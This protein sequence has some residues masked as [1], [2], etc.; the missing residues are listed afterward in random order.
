MHGNIFSGQIASNKSDFISLFEDIVVRISVLEQLILL[1]YE[2]FFC[3]CFMSFNGKI[4]SVNM[5]I[6]CKSFDRRY[7]DRIN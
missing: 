1:C 2:T 5:K 6:Y 7:N 4:T 3:S